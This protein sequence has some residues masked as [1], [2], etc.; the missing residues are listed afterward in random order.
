M[1]NEDEKIS[2]L[3]EQLQQTESSADADSEADAAAV[4]D[5]GDDSSTPTDTQTRNPKLE[6]AFA[7]E[8]TQMHGFYVRDSA[9][10]S[11]QETRAN[12]GSTLAKLG[13]N[14]FEGREFQEAMIRVASDHGAEVVDQMLQ[15]R[16]ISADADQISSVYETL[17][18]EPEIELDTDGAD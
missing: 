2:D 4:D 16:G 9:W 17:A 12:V 6:P 11:V 1:P 5:D 8:E 13:I 14:D 18:T 7:F 15:A 10:E 3:S